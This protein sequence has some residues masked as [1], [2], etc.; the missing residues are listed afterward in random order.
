MEKKHRVLLLIDAGIN[1]ALGIILLFFPLG[2]AAFFGV[3]QTDTNLYPS[4]LGAVLFGIGIALLVDLY[5]A[6]QGLRG[7]GLGGAVVI[8]LAAASALL[9]WLVLVPFELPT[10]GV[11]LL[12]S[13]AVVVLVIG[14]VEL[15]AKPWRH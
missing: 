5:G 9:L 3:P 15:L 8:N 13:T 7:L 14:F 1:L 10:R 12:W 6:P 2:A 11:V 4:L